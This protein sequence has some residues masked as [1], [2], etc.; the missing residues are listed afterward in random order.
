[1]TG[2]ALTE[3]Y[4]ELGIDADELP[5]LVHRTVDLGPTS[6]GGRCLNRP[7]FLAEEQWR[8]LEEDLGH[9]HSA[10]QA[11]PGRLFGGDLGAFARA[12]GMTEPQVTA[13]LR[14]SSASLTKLAR[15]DLYHDGD[16][17]RLMELN[18]GSTVGGLDNALLNRAVLNHPAVAD[19][20]KANN[21]SFVD[22]MAELAALLFAECDIPPGQRPLMAA[23]DWPSSFETLEPQLRASAEALAPLGIE[24][25]ACH[26]GQLEMRDGRVWLHGRP[27]DVLYRVFLIEDLLAPES[28]ELVDPVLRAA[29]R[30]EVKIFTP[31]D[32]EL[33]GSKAALAMLSDEANRHLYSAAELASLDRVLPWTRMVRP[34]PVTVDGEQVQLRELAVDQR[35]DLV[36]KPAMLHS[37]SGVVLGWQADA[38]EW[39]RALEAAMGG[40]YVLQRRIRGLPEFFLFTDGIAPMLLK[41]GVFTVGRGFG[42]A[43]VGGSTDLT[44]GVLNSAGGATLGCCFHETD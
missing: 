24:A 4:L 27:V 12:A 23:A 17:F 21:L 38:D 43:I 14:A 20:V 29:E 22:T 19:F 18:I 44:G 7:V 39:R 9:L 5:D 40:P 1:M 34:G 42:G 15:A 25:V 16:A 35:E 32:S 11:L 37:G 3:R 41:W 2:N 33:Y 13:I 6:Y 26:L 30:G 28:A 8:R 36:L 10:L 31:I